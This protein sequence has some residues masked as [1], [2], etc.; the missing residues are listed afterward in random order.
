MR[1]IELF[2]FGKMNKAMFLLYFC[3]IYIKFICKEKGTLSKQMIC[4]NH[5]IFNNNLIQ[6]TNLHWKPLIMRSML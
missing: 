3:H 2:D 6:R 4:I 5:M 1:Q